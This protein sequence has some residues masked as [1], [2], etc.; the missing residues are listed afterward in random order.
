MNNC[1]SDRKTEAIDLRRAEQRNAVVDELW[2]VSLFSL[3]YR[4]IRD[5]GFPWHGVPE[6]HLQIFC[7]RTMDHIDTGCNNHVSF[8]SV[9][10][11][12]H[13]WECASTSQS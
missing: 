4:V 3:L 2:S 12:K 13:E 10:H 9:A 6:G 7:T 1:G 5:S 8:L 11:E